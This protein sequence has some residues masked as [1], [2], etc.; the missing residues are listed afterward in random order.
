MTRPRADQI[1]ELFHRLRSFLDGHP[2]VML[3]MAL[4]RERR[5][6]S[7]VP[8]GYKTRTL[9]DGGSSGGP[10]ITVEEDGAKESISVTSTEMTAFKRMDWNQARDEHHSHTQ[11]ML[12]C[13]E[14][15][16]EQVKAFSYHVEQIE[17]ATRRL[18]IDDN[19]WCK[20]HAALGFNEP[21]GDHGRRGFCGWCEGFEREYRQLPPKVL[22]DRRARGENPNRAQIAV[23]LGI[24]VA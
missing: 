16:V 23:A 19:L 22:L 6:G 24:K 18:A 8:D 1:D 7:N 21:V 14:R 11:A 5:A 2:E 12:R 13:A 9:G 20:H 17:G 15:M 10:R 4:E 3:R